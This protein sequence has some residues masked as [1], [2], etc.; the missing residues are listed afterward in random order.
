MTFF[1]DGLRRLALMDDDLV[2]PEP[3]SDSNSAAARWRMLLLI[4]AAGFAVAL[5]LRMLLIGRSLW[6]DESALAL[7][8]CARSFGQLLEPLAYDQ[9]APIGFLL[10]ERASV[11]A[12]GPN[13]VA[14]RLF[15]FLASLAT[16]VLIHR[17]CARN[18]GPWAAVVAVALAGVMPALVY[19]S[20]ELKQYSSDVAFGLLIL[21]LTSNVLR[22]GLT[23]GRA[24]ALGLAG[25]AAVWC[26]HPS[27]F[28]LAAAGTILILHEAAHKRFHRA[29]LAAAVSAC[30][31]ASF[32]LEYIYFLKDLQANPFLA[33]YW[34][35]A[36][37]K[38]PPTSPR[39]LRV[40]MAVGMG[41]FE[42]LF[43]NEQVDV[44]L[45][46]RMGVFTAAAWMIGLI[47][48]G[49]SGR[50]RMRI[51]LV[52]PLLFGVVGCL[53]HAY[54]LKGRLALFTAAATLPVVAAGIAGLATSRNRANRAIGAVLGF[55][56]LLLPATQAAQF[57]VEHPRLHDARSVLGQ[58]ARAWR[59]GDVVVVDRY[60]A[61]PFQYYQSF[62][63][64]KGLERVAI[65]RSERALCEPQD[66]AAE[67]TRWR[68]RSRV[69][70][71]L[72]T[73]LPDPV[74]LSRG[75]LKVI[76]DQAGEPLD[77]ASCRRYSAHLYRLRGDD[78]GQAVERVGSEGSGSIAGVRIP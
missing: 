9:A 31:L 60:S 22:A 71:L 37:L 76:L 75:A 25:L 3:G 66:L 13:E 56:S 58:V 11:V 17:F 38:F 43:L 72:D 44:D 59:P 33:A 57:L 77:S 10:I 35:S 50:R 20:G 8:I 34:E 61:L 16:L 40:Y 73:A 4:L 39:D 24:L 46:M 53:M 47:A 51:L 18:I 2:E 26:S 62:G 54:P 12:F 23:A 67:I 5:R 69:W 68:G 41:V 52:G 6:L 55:W 48:L 1:T 45:S 63:G 65:T 70:F 42:S 36:I 7:N 32:G 28:V 30:W 27:V 74:N 29:A 19:Y 21:Y 78:A 64:V 14:L 49:Q 15:P